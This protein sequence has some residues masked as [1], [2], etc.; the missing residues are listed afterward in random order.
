MAW[1]KQTDVLKHG[2]I[3]GHN[4]LVIILNNLNKSALKG[5][6]LSFFPSQFSLD[7]NYHLYTI[8]KAS[9]REG[10]RD[11]DAFLRTARPEP[12][13]LLRDVASL[14]RT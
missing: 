7:I 3:T 14:T 12:T 5:D 9:T 8:R 4:Y 10:R 6:W 11:S 13:L 1:I 2:S